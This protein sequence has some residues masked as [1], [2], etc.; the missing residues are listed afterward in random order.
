[1]RGR[2]YSH[3]SRRRVLASRRAQAW[4]GPQVVHPILVG[5]TRRG[6]FAGQ[7]IELKFHDLNFD[8]AVVAAAGAIST[9][10][11]II[12]QG[13]TESERIGRKCTLRKIG[14][15]FEM[16]LGAQTAA[17]ACNDVV[18]VML[19]QDKQANGAVPTISGVNGILASADY[20]SFNNLNN[21][22]R[23][24]TLMDRTYDINQKAGG[25]D[26]TT[27]DYGAVIKS[28]AFYK[29][30]NVPIE[31]SG[32]TG[33]I[34]EIRSNNLILLV[35]SKSGLATFNSKFRLRFSDS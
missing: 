16:Q 26:G 14:F 13:T 3:K 28:D 5:V 30:L 12:A 19:V 9:S 21:K 35:I 20:Q 24:R 29:D 34:T 6:R 31:F 32:A 4:T 11:N 17:S 25:G 33:A 7:P 18:R 22:N 27:E 1:M 8:D 10:L 2:R 23:F 15:R